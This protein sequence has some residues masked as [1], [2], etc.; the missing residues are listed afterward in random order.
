MLRRL[1]LS[2]IAASLALIPTVV[3][4]AQASGRPFKA[5][6]TCLAVGSDLMS[7]DSYTAGASAS[8][9]VASVRLSGA[10]GWTVTNLLMQV[11]AN[12]GE[13]WTTQSGSSGYWI[14]LFNG[15]TAAQ[16]V[17][18]VSIP[19]GGKPESYQ[20]RGDLTGVSDVASGAAM[21]LTATATDGVTEQTATSTCVIP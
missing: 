2:V 1:V 11:D 16:A 18:P 12:R 9:W 5:S 10:S 15:D 21:L 3:P 6:T 17:R 4:D 7:T 20:L 19:L 14:G 8:D 13:Y